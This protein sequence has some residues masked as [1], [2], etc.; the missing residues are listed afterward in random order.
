MPQVYIVYMG[1]QHASQYPTYELHL[2][3]LKEILVNCSPSESLVY[4]YQ[5][6][7]S[8]FAAKLSID[9]ADKL[10]ERDGIVSVFRS[11]TLKLRTTRSWDFLNFPQSVNRNPPLESDIIVGML[12][13]GIWPESKSFNDKGLGPPPKKWKGAC[14]NMTCNNKIIGARYYNS[15]GDYT[16]NEPSPR[17][18]KGHGTHTASTAVGRSVSHASLY[19]LAKG[20]ARGAV[21]SA[22]LAVY[23]V[24]WAFGCTDQDIL[25]AFDDAISDGVDIISLS[26]G[27]SNSLDYFQDSIAIGSFH[28]MANG[29]LTSAAAG[30]NGPKHG[31]VCNVAPWMVST[32]AS[33]IDRH[34]IDKVVTGDHIST[35]GAS[36]NT[37]ATTNRFHPLI[38][39]PGNATT[40]PGDCS[41]PDK[42]VVKGKILLCKLLSYETFT[43]GI[44]GLISIDDSSLN[45]SFLFPIP[46]I[47]ISSLDGL[48]LLNYINNTNSISRNPVANIQKSE[49]VFDSEAPLVASF[50]SRGPNLITPDILKPDISA[51]GID[52]L[53][54]WSRVASVSNLPIDTRVVNYNIISG[55][56]KACP[57]VTGVAAY[58]KSFHQNWSPAAIMSALMTT[59]KPMYPSAGQ[60]QL[61]YGAGQL[62]PAKAVDPGLVYDAGASDYVQMLCDSGYNETMIRIVTGDSSSC[63]SST[64]T[65]TARDLNYPSM[66]L[67]VRSGKAFAA[68]FLRTVTNVGSA[69]RGKYKAE[70]RADRRLNVVVNP[71]KLRF[72]ELNEKRQFTVSVSGGPLPGNSTA[73][74]T[75]IWSDGKHLVRSVMVV[76]T[77][78]SS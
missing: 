40:S 64:S 37:F 32:A 69:R 30:N 44:Q 78:F 67:H 55:T 4:S 73:P 75:V 50:S 57:H 15:F 41:M 47:V 23:K 60:D 8:G 5:Q 43:K 71:S 3:L 27:G 21:P 62:N 6:S 72:S 29:I 63:S 49:A 42:N 52:I 77:D 70:V 14:V 56:S 11:K 7:F 68:K 48:N 34:I 33:S 24:C 39:L 12:D 16:S 17:D 2:N 35:L 58:V 74:A 20:T 61:S 19:D 28:A 18:F 45:I 36:V 76:Y 66:A 31:T 25:A 53:A 9:E 46:F 26:I 51:P 59:A 38:Y 22:R 54:A 65:G 13:S 1:A 10:N